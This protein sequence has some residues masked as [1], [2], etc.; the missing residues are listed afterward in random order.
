MIDM[1]TGEVLETNMRK[2][3][4][5]LRTPYNYDIDQESLETGLECP[6]PTLTQQNFKEETDINTIVERFG[7]TGQMPENIKTPSYGDY[8]NIPDFQTAL[9][10]VVAAKEAFMELP[11]KVRARFENDPQQYLEFVE[12]IGHSEENVAEARRLGLVPAAAEPMG[13]PIG[14]TSEK[15]AAKE[16]KAAE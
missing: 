1:E 3:G 8:T 5:F 10:Q 14:S 4:V 15:P 16:I 6:E 13:V 9:N 11:A 12:T 2:Y 7:V